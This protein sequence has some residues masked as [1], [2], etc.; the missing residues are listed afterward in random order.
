MG[1]P[2]SRLQKVLSP[3]YV[4]YGLVLFCLNGPQKLDPVVG[5]LLVGFSIKPNLGVTPLPHAERGMG[6]GPG[7]IPSQSQIREG[8]YGQFCP[9]T[10]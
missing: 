7:Q 3:S 6:K 9:N 2:C 10:T 8:F 5:R 1:F 4:D